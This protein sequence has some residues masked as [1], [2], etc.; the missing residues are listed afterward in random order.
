MD[1]DEL[2][3]DG[4]KSFSFQPMW[5]KQQKSYRSFRAD[6]NAGS[7]TRKRGNFKQDRQREDGSDDRGMRPHFRKKSPDDR[8]FGDRRGGGSF[9]YGDRKK[10]FIKREFEPV[11]TAEFYPEDSQFETIINA[12]RLTCKTYELFSFARLFLEKP[13]R[14]VVVIKKTGAA[15]KDDPNLYLSLDDNF[16]FLNENSAVQHILDYHLE[17]YFTIE[18][19]SGEAPKGTFVCMHKCGITGKMLCPPN[20]HRYQEILLE[21]HD[22]YLPN[23]PFGRFKDKLE[24]V[25]E[26]EAIDAWKAEASK[27]I[28]YTPKLE[29]H[30]EKFTKFAELRHFFIEHFKDQAIK[31]ADSFRVVGT[32]YAN[33]PRG[34]LSKSIFTLLMREK[35]FP[36][37]FSNNLRGKLR[38]AH[39][40]IYKIHSE[41]SKSKIACICAVKRKFRSTEDKFEGEI[42]TIVDFIDNHQNVKISELYKRLYPDAPEHIIGDTDERFSVFAKDLNWLIHEG[43]VSEFEDGRLVSTAIMSKEQLDA[44]RKSEAAMEEKVEAD[45]KE[46]VEQDE[47]EQNTADGVNPKG[48]S[49]MTI[50]NGADGRKTSDELQESEGAP[51]QESV[52]IDS[53]LTDEVLAADGGEADIGSLEEEISKFETSLNEVGSDEEDKEF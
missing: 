48:S 52:Q 5:S 8:S 26:Q 53:A 7:F 40:T 50:D 6:G 20:Y 21:H 31:V 46:E 36:L 1:T 13:E 25:T 22:K 43:Y 4:L 3:L 19:S 24:T 18:E 23:V 17:K 39:F 47:A 51:K 28:T 16:V 15:A 11:V 30:E 38:R 27:A 9:R 44:M 32:V 29:G 41:K 33:M 34:L 35:R 37:G 2:D 14:F 49:Q 10:R 12:C 45:S 42:Q